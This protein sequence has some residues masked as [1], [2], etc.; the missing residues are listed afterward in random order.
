MSDVTLDH[1]TNSRD[2]SLIAR[3][4]YKAVLGMSLTKFC[5]ENQDLSKDEI[6]DAVIKEL[7]KQENNCFLGGLLW[8]DVERN[9]RISISARKTELKIYG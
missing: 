2:H 1:W 4:D 5:I 9:L 3:I 6:F 8:K 7:R